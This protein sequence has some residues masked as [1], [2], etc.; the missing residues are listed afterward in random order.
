MIE[1]PNNNNFSPS[2][3]S[4]LGGGKWV[5]FLALFLESASGVEIRLK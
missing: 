1:S 2:I 5:K 3:N 4:N